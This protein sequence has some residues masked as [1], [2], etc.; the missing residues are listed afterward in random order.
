[1]TLLSCTGNQS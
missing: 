1:M